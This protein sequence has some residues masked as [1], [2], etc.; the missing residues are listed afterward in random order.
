MWSFKRSSA[1]SVSGNLCTHTFW[2]TAEGAEL[3]SSVTVN[4]QWSGLAVVFR[5]GSL[6]DLLGLQVELLG[7]KGVARKSMKNP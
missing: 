4:R 6:V 1:T 3:A 2:I 7:V 5:V